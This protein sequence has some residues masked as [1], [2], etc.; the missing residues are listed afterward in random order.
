MTGIFNLIVREER[1]M[2]RQAILDVLNNLEVVEINGGDSPYIL[3]ENNEIVR[4][5]LNAVGKSL[6]LIVK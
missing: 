2:N 6:A 3:V 5:K 1:A 4:Q